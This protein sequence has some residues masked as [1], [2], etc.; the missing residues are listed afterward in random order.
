LLPREI[1]ATGQIES[2]VDDVKRD[3]V[4]AYARLDVVRHGHRPDEIGE[5]AIEHRA[6]AERARIADLFW[7]GFDPGWRQ[8]IRYLHEVAMNH[9]LIEILHECIDGEMIDSVLEQLSGLAIEL[10]PKMLR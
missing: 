6:I 1:L 8:N 2:G 5:I 7:A 9:N 4:A 3:T 10:L